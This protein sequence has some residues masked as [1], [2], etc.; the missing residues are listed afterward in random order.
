MT[1]K[2][3]GSGLMIKMSFD[4]AWALSLVVCDIPSSVV[5]TISDEEVRDTACDVMF[6]LEA[7]LDKF[8]KGEEV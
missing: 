7:G 4:E 8:C 3:S 2:K 6:E 1:I 5:D